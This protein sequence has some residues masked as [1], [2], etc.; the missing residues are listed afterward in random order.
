[1]KPLRGRHGGRIA[2][3]GESLAQEGRAARPRG[4][5][6]RLLW[7]LLALLGPAVAA[8][9]GGLSP[10]RQVL[11]RDVLALH[12]I[13]VL[14]AGRLSPEEIAAKTGL[15]DG[16]SLLEISPREIEARLRTHPWIRDAHVMRLLPAR[17]LIEVALR[18]PV[19]RVTAASAV[20]GAQIVL[21]DAEGRAIA[22]SAG[23]PFAKLP[24]IVSPRLPAAGEIVPGIAAATAAALAV[25][26]SSFAGAGAT[27]FLGAEN[28]PNSVALELPS[29]AARVL[30]GTGDLDLKLARLALV[31]AGDRTPARAAAEIDLRF[32]DQAVLRGLPFPDGTAH[33][34]QA[35]GGAPAPH[36]R[37]G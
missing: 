8:G 12:S 4:K 17:V 19:A 34:A 21:V 6:R 28:D 2:L 3:R 18:E 11:A 35:P 33:S 1:M 14:G 23:E 30:L 29:L 7:T 13:C 20:A 5:G 32:A 9:A 24:I 36:N 15:A 26:R 16:T 27:F 37:A 22:Q 10:L 31:L 25:T